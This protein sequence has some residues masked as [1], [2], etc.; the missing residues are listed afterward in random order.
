MSPDSTPFSTTSQVRSRL[1]VAPPNYVMKIV[2]KDGARVLAERKSNE[3]D[4]SS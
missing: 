2:D 1:V 4:N 3:V